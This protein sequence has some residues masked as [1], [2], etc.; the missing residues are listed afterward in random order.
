VVKA[1][2]PLFCQLV[3]FGI[4]FDLIGI[5]LQYNRPTDSLCLAR[6][7]VPSLAFT[8][9]LS[10][11]FVKTWRIWRIFD[12][13]R[14]KRVVITNVHL[15]T[16]FG[17]FLSLDTTILLI[18]T[19]IDPVKPDIAFGNP[20]AWICNSPL[21]PTFELALHGYKFLL[22]VFGAFLA[23]QI[24]NIQVSQ[25]NESRHIAFSIY[26]VLIVLTLVLIVSN[27]LTNQRSIFI[28]NSMGELIIV[29]GILATLFGPKLY[30]LYKGALGDDNSDVG[31]R[32]QH[33]MS[34]MRG[35]Q[36]VYAGGAGGSSVHGSQTN[37]YSSV[38]GGHSGGTVNDYTMGS[39][40]VDSQAPQLQFL[41]H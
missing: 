26:N 33:G 8:I 29:W 39:G 10:N 27:S 4:F 9:F 1:A 24:R 20:S 2:S 12:N 19:L 37:M 25:F 36:S 18:W 7:W 30:V 32:T 11:L 31:S 28:I 40:A 34:L 16:M 21:L 41:E 13:K 17:W 15:L 35:T 5:L 23:F 6:V 38:A 14:M 3:L 22:L